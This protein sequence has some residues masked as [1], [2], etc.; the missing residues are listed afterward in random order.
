MKY[1]VIIPIKNEGYDILKC[2]SSILDTNYHDHNA[3]VLLIDDSNL[4]NKKILKSYLENKNIK[5]LRYFENLELGLSGSCNFAANKSKGEYLVFINAD[6]ILPPS[7]FSNLDFDLKNNQYDTI[8]I[9][10]LVKNTDDIYGAYLDTLNRKKYLENTYFNRLIDKKNISYTEG[11]TVS[12][13]KFISSGGF[14]HQKNNS[15]VAGEDLI[16]GFNLIESGAKGNISYASA[17]EHLVPSNFKD[18]FYHRFIRGYGVPQISFFYFRKKKFFL[19]IKTLFRVLFKF[20][21]L[22]LLIPLLSET[23]EFSKYNKKKNFFLKLLFLNFIDNLIL[24]YGEL[25]G[26]F[27][28]LFAVDT[29]KIDLDSE[30]IKSKSY[31]MI[32]VTSAQDTKYSVIKNACLNKFDNSMKIIAAEKN[33]V[34]YSKISF[35]NLERLIY[36]ILFKFGYV[37]DYQNFSSRLINLI[38]LNEVDYVL[39]NKCNF[40]GYKTLDIIKKINPCVKIIFWGEDNMFIKQNSSKNFIKSLNY[41]DAYYSVDRGDIENK[42]I[43]E[44][45]NNHLLSHPTIN[46]DSILKKISNSSL[47]LSEINFIGYYD[48]KRIEYL[49]YLGNSGLKIKIYGNGW[50]LCKDKNYKNLSFHNPVY[51]FDYQKL[52]NNSLVSINFLRDFTK[53]VINLKSIEI[54]A[55]GGLLLSE[56]SEYQDKLFKDNKEAFYFSNKEELLKKIN[57]IQSNKEK[58][59]LIRNNALKVIKAGKFATEDVLEDIFLKL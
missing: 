55:Y 50:K 29:K 28:I 8:S 39:L 43:I 38:K 37:Y 59:D 54:P 1:S 4:E 42:K 2:L 3:E 23:I 36:K 52:I 16:L 47:D 41:F 14:L 45:V 31:K 33:F 15:I 5:N 51:G 18:F 11:F 48:K 56:Y 12:K 49:S 24:I 26:L 20:L 25:R 27:R 21:R 58:L 30:Y 13:E 9:Q 6:N 10:N 53:D 44:R 46:K 32:Y 19:F 22:L 34:N 7:F 57:Y 40:I 17:L 35:F